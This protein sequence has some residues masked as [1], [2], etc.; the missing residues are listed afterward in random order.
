M[1]MRA[2]GEWALDEEDEMEY[3]H[4][5]E[6]GETS[7]EHKRQDLVYFLAVQPQNT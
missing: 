1:N 6:V 5:L 3:N 4:R 2:A 7:G